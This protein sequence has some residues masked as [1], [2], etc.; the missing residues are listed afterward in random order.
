MADATTQFFT[1]LEERGHDPRLGKVRGSMRFDLSNGSRRARWLVTVDRGDITV[2]RRNGKADCVVRT[3]QAVFEAVA[4]G[5]LNAMAAV[6]RGLVQIE[7]EAELL[8]FFQRLLPAPA[9]DAA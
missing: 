7:G 6:L 5:E 2:S 8:V 1:E 9:R 4:R 3:D